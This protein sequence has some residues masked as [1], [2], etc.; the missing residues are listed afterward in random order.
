MF[1][2][3][4]TWW[5][6][7]A[8]IVIMVVLTGCQAVQGLDITQA[9][10]NDWAVKSAESQGTLQFE[11]VPG[12][13]SKLSADEKQTLL[14]LQNVKVAITNA[15]IQDAQHL[16]A[17]GSITYGKGTIPFKLA[18]EGTKLI[19][20]IEGAK[21]PL[22]FDLFDSTN[23]SVTKLLPDA[24]QSQLGPKLMETKSAI[25]GLIL[26][27]LPN[28]ASLSV[29]SVSDKVNGETLALQQA[30]IEMNG[31][32]LASLLKKL[33]ANVLADE[34][35]LKELINQLY[36]A[37][38]PV[39]EEQIK[40]GSTDF[41]LRLLSNKQLAVGLVYPSIH[42]FLE[43]MSASL[44]TVIKG[45]SSAD[46]TLFPAQDLWNSDTSLK[47]NLYIDAD[48]QIRKQTVELNVPLRHTTSG[49]SALKIS[50]MSE[51]WHINKLVT[52]AAIDTSSG[53]VNVGTDAS[54]TYSLLNQL[55]KQSLFYKL[56]KEDL[57]VTKK[58]IHLKLKNSAQGATSDTPEPFINADNITVVPVRFISE[59]LGA[60]VGWNGALQQ[61]TIKDAATGATII[62]TLDS[63]VAMVN[64]SPIQLESPA[65]LYN[66]STF[67]PIRFITEQLGGE[68]SFDD[69]TRVVTIKRN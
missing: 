26:G 44:D 43:N 16:S 27:N 29:T 36:E 13:T 37:L 69:L 35:G 42:D 52:A 3:K 2:K 55:D 14:A 50:Y 28:P 24:I 31:S 7:A 48:K 22:V 51:S 53:V 9:I 49:A 39:I 11:L 62:L 47:A 45:D 5:I 25:I 34:A 8:T 60:E 67:V 10:K 33:L 58:E 19:L 40:G 15:K 6:S 32:E 56:L 4:C 21:K 18:S 57:K 54:S 68:V 20:S 30:H 63:K 17:D 65:A 61:V 1:K 41:T 66:G 59:K 46:P 64:G 38:S 23:M 12:D